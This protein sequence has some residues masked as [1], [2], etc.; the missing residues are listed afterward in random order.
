MRVI[1]LTMT[2]LLLT[3]CSSDPRLMNTNAGQDGPDEFGI[4][5]TKPLQM[6][7]DLNI[8]PAPT[9]GGGNI[10]DATPMGD[11]VAALGGNPER[12]AVQGI[13][14]SDGGLVSYVSRFGRDPAIRQ[15]TAQ[16]DVEWRSRHS[17]RLLEVWARTNVYYRAYEPMTLDSWAELERWRPT[18][19]RLPA[20]PPRNR[21]EPLA[22]PTD[23]A[24]RLQG[25]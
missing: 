7:E 11:A 20:A 13:G 21:G 5:P 19:V 12:L 6:P 17:R 10:T 2:M 14:A 8:L 18:G 4:V 16:E 25:D 22:R 23:N 24:P 1:A 9:P 3:A 15:V